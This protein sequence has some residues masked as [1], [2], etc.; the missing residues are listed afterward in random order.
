LILPFIEQD[1]LYRGIYVKYSVNDP[2]N[3]LPNYAGI[4]GLPGNPTVS[5]D[6]KTFVCPSTP[7]HQ[8]DYE[9]YFV[10]LGLPDAGP[11][12]LGATDYAVVQG[13]T[14]YFNAPANSGLP[15]CAPTSPT[16]T[17]G[18]FSDDKEGA[19]GKLGHM[20]PKGMQGKLNFASIT[21][22][23]SNTIL[24]GEDAGR[25]QNYITGH[26]AYTTAS[27]PPP[28]WDGPN[29]WMLNA[30]WPDYNSAIRVMGFSGDGK[31][32]AA[33][34]CAVNCNNAWQFYS[35][36]PAGVNT[37]RGD[38]SVQFMIQD[39]APGVLAALVTRS[40]GEVINEQ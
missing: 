19:M 1:N 34:C 22:G 3:W 26:I 15:T 33:G 10:S 29:G 13:Y 35:F 16:T 30:S 7:S 4:F 38:G 39:I 11:F 8:V 5:V 12:P 28:Y 23:L 14:K 6:V 24:M 25:H 18:I 32:A 21:D 9:P 37:V 2:N 17:N 31:T 20:T 40:G 27:P 36:H